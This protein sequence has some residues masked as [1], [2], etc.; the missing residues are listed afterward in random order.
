[1]SEYHKFIFIDI[2][3][4]I[5]LFKVFFCLYIIFFVCSRWKDK[6]TSLGKNTYC[7][8]LAELSPKSVTV[9]T[10]YNQAVVESQRKS[11]EY[12]SEKENKPCYNDDG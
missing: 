11:R 8:F 10:Y 7:I 6:I 3:I 1:M 5:S 9:Q 4:E 2:F 12:T